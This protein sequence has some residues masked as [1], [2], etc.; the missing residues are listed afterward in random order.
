MPTPPVPAEVTA[1]SVGGALLAGV[2]RLIDLARPARKPLHPRGRVAHA[3]LDRLGLVPGIGVPF[4]DEAGADEVLVRQSRAIGLPA[5]WP[6][7]QGLA[8]RVPTGEG[9]RGDLLLATTGWGR[10]SRYVLTVSR[11]PYGRP[12]TTLLPY[13]SAAGSVVL[14]ARPSGDETMALAVS[15]EGGPWR[16]FADL[17]ISAR[18]ATDEEIAFDPV[19]HPVPGLEQYAWVRRLRAPAYRTAQAQRTTLKLK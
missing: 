2:T 13:R 15:V 4:V 5:P 7:V 9:R 10:F 1:A 12:F 6:D 8:L 16:H 18:G 3:R 17:R 11:T 14:G 19:Q